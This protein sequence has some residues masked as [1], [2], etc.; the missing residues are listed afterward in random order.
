MDSLEPR[1]AV[2]V[3]AV[4]GVAVERDELAARLLAQPEQELVEDLGPG[5]VEDAAV[6]E[7]AVEIEEARADARARPSIVADRRRRQPGLRL[8]AGGVRELCEQRRCSPP[9]QHELAVM[10]GEVVGRQRA[11]RVVERV[12]R[13]V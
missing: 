9:L 12:L 11:A 3:G 5:G 10:A 8:D 2:E 7:D 4:V 1:A 13:R 6:G